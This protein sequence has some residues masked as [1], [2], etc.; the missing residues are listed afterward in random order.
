MKKLLGTLSPAYGAITGHGLFGKISDSPVGGLLPM[1]LGVNRRKKRDAKNNEVE[2][3]SA[4][5]MKK[6]GSVKAK[7]SATRGDGIC[8]KGH[9]KGKMR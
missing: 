6:G 1:A 3:A 8:K 2:D 9:T 4:P 7:S 5:A